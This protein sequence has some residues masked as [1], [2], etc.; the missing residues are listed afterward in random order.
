[1][2]FFWRRRTRSTRIRKKDPPT[3]KKGSYYWTGI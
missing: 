2:N 3:R 1:M